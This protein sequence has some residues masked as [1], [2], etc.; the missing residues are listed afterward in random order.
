MDDANMPNLLS[1]PFMGYPDTLQLYNAT[2]AFVLRPPRQHDDPWCADEPHLCH[3][4][5]YYFVGDA[6]SGLGSAHESIGLR[7]PWNAPQ[8]HG[9]CIWP[10]GK[11]GCTLPR[12]GRSLALKNISLKSERNR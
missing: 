6:A 1:I 9:R 10:L 12:G 11:R 2:R 8:C 5:T 7:H 3:G 4:N